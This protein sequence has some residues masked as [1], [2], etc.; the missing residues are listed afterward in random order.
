MLPF[1]GHGPGVVLLQKNQNTQPMKSS[2]FLRTIII[3]LILIVYGCLSALAGNNTG[4]KKSRKNAAALEISASIS[5]LGIDATDTF[6]VKLYNY[7]NATDSI[8]IGGGQDFKFSLEKDSYYIIKVTKPG[9]SKQM[10]GI[11]TGIPEGMKS[12][13]PFRLRTQVRMMKGE[14][15][16][17]EMQLVMFDEELSRFTSNDP[18]APCSIE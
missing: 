4:R 10:I 18:V 7:T 9:Y 11:Y 12:S 3:A 17:A 14:P 15:N 16:E 6:M 5:A 2:I 13:A 8:K 1:T